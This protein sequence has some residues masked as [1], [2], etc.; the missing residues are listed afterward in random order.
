LTAATPNE[1]NPRPYF[2]RAYYSFDRIRE[3]GLDRA[4]VS[5][6]G[7][8]KIN[9]PMESIKVQHAGMNHAQTVSQ[10][11]SVQSRTSRRPNKN[12][13]NVTSGTQYARIPKGTARVAEKF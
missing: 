8:T 5:I 12:T 6:I 7:T 3:L 10:H 9:D 1:V 2:F 11:A 13:K 4:D